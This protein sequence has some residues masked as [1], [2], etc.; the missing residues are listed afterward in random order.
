MRKL[1]KMLFV[2][3]FIV[4]LFYGLF[5]KFLYGTQFLKYIKLLPE[6]I[7]VLFLIT[8][9][10]IAKEKRGFQLIDISLLVVVVTICAI[11]IFMNSSFSSIAVFIRDFFIPILSLILLRSLRLDKR[12]IKFYYKSL[13]YLSIIFLLSSLYFGYMQYTSSYEYTANWYTNKVFY[14]FDEVSSIKVSTA[15]GRVRA[16]GLVG[17][18]AKY[19]FYSVFAFVFITL[20][21]KRISYFIVSFPLALLN[22]WFSTNKSSLVC[23][24]ALGL[25]EILLIFYRGKHKLILGAFMLTFTVFGAI[26][27]FVLNTDKFFS[28]QERFYLWGSYDYIGFENAILGLDVFSYFGNENGWMSVIDNTYLFGFTSFGVVVFAFFIYYIAKQ[29]LKTSYLLFISVMFLLLGMTTNLFSGRCFFT[30]YCVIAG[31]ESS[32]ISYNHRIP[33]HY[34]LFSS[35]VKRPVLR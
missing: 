5:I 12:M 23:L 10:F 27:Y 1:N 9:F 3:Y 16:L 25:L 28:I 26:G 13:A 11:S 30:I 35:S 2:L 34:E 32:K 14:G 21:Y 24:F 4:L 29:S 15:D 6:I 20:Y 19:G 8:C 31:I 33:K 22:I 7:L 17:S 18:S